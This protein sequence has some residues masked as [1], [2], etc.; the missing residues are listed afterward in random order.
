M[1]GKEVLRSCLLEGDDTEHG[2]SCLHDIMSDECKKV[3]REWYQ[4]NWGFS[5]DDAGGV[6]FIVWV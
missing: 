5:E 4:R 6:V 2:I 1:K 3:Y